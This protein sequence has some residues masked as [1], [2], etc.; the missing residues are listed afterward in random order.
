[1]DMVW[2]ETHHGTP[3]KSLAGCRENRKSSI[4]LCGAQ[5]GRGGAYIAA[6]MDLAVASAIETVA[7]GKAKFW[8]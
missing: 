7:M 2:P 3:F 6:G 4:V 8:R 5:D 1:M